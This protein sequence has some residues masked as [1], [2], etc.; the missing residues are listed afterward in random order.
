MN[1]IHHVDIRSAGYTIYFNDFMLKAFKRKM[2]KDPKIVTGSYNGTRNA[3]A[4]FV[5]AETSG[6][7]QYSW[8]DNETKTY[9]GQSAAAFGEHVE[10]MYGG[11]PADFLPL[12]CR[13]LSSYD[14]ELVDKALKAPALRI[15]LDAYH[16]SNW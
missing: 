5:V 15:A 3:L 2:G 16:G 4:I 13:G 8:G 10:K 1:P 12:G 11:I 6:A 14:P 7:G 9:C